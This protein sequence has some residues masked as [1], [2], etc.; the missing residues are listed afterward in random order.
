MMSP[1]R[2]LRETKLVVR[3]APAPASLA[4]EH[5]GASKLRPKLYGAWHFCLAA[6][7]LVV[8]FVVVHLGRK[9][10]FSGYLHGQDDGVVGWDEVKSCKTEHAE[11]VPSVHCVCSWR[12]MS[13]TSSGIC[14][15]WLVSVT[16]QALGPL[17]ASA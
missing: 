3:P 9:M 7:F 12:P 17:L 11:I 16:L 2:M 5:I 4:W 1:G 14:R 15:G 6:M 8:P 10:R 13:A